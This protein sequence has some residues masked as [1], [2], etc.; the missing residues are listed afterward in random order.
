MLIDLEH[1]RCDRCQDKVLELYSSQDLSSKSCEIVGTPWYCYN[2][3]HET[4]QTPIDNRSF[5][6]RYVSQRQ[7]W[8]GRIAE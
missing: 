3:M 1:M 4:H 2:C 6:V 5:R 8:I 7:R